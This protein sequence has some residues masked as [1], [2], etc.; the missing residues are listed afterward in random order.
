MT[1]LVI[2]RGLP[3]SGKTTRAREWVAIAPE[4]RARVNRDDLRQM[5]YG[6]A[7][8]V[9]SCE[10]RVITARDKIISAVLRGGRDVIY[11]DTNLPARTVA[12]LRD[13]ARKSNASFEVID[14][15]SVPIEECL[16]RNAARQDKPPV[17]EKWIREQYQLYIAQPESGGILPRMRR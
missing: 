9:K 17:P 8:M 3:A 15:T 11:D 5:M 1:I 4:Q 10:P 7:Y 2:T 6:T 16:R 13:L 14:L 12:E